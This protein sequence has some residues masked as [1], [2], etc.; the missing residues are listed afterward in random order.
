M[1]DEVAAGRQAYVVCPLVEESEKIQARSATEE[2]ARLADEVWPDLR[3]GLLHGQMP[4]KEKEA[5]MDRLPRPASST[6]WWPPP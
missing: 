2:R 1:A 3:L 4:S 5:V 6:C